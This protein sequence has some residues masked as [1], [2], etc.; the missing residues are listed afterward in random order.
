MS[1]FA[2]KSGSAE[3]ASNLA[4]MRAHGTRH[5]LAPEQEFEA[6]LLTK[7]LE[8]LQAA[9]ATPEGENEESGTSEQFRGFATE[10]LG[11]EFARQ[12]GVGIARI[13]R[14]GISESR[15]LKF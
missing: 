2:V 11:Q 10:M 9:Y 4:Q 6:V 12:G 7:M 14:T 3:S 13:L 15:Q 1:S 5:G 8:D